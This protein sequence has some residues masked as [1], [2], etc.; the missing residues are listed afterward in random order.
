MSTASLAESLGLPSD[1][2]RILS[3]RAAPPKASHA[4]SHL[5]AQRNYLLHANASASRGTATTG[6]GAGAKKRSPPYVP[7]R[8]LDAPGFR[9]DYYLNLIDWSSENRVAIALGDVTYVWDAES[10]TVNGLGDGK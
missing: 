4:T 3:F 5:D 6:A 8:V 9:D 7:D 1:K 2:C 10:G